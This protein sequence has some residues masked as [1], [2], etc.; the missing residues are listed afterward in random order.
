VDADLERLTR[1]AKT[2]RIE[3]GELGNALS[4]SAPWT[5]N[6]GAMFQPCPV[7]RRSDAKAAKLMDAWD[8]QTGRRSP[9][10]LCLQL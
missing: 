6:K 1:L 9:P 10:Q 7:Y 5:E 8:G 3:L 2:V 4:S